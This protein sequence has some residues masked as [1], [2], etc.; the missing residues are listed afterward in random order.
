MT[1]QWTHIPIMAQQIA[2]MLL[3]NPDGVYIDGTLGLGGHTRFFL[4]R[5]SSQAQILGFDKDQEALE[6]AVDL[7]LGVY[8]LGKV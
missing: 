4:Q 7:S 2:D 6:M 8:K 1:Q 5:L 3:Q